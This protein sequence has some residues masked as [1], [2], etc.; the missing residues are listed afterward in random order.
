MGCIRQRKPKLERPT[1]LQ[2]YRLYS[3]VLGERDVYY[4][5]YETSES[6]KSVQGF[7]GRLSD[8]VVDV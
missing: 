5:L 7:M 4:Q 2:Q 6:V 8:L 3:N 1:E